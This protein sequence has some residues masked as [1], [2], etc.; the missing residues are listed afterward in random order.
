MSMPVNVKVR[1]SSF[2]KSIIN[3]YCEPAVQLNIVSL[4]EC[5]FGCSIN[6]ECHR[7]NNFR[8]CATHSP[9]HLHRIRLIIAANLQVDRTFFCICR[10]VCFGLF[11]TAR[12]IETHLKHEFVMHDKLTTS[13][14]IYVPH[15]TSR[16]KLCPFQIVF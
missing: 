9:C 2:W 5:L 16:S 3:Y 10:C 1:Q 4:I 12:I 7:A 8:L 6:F 11:I 14:N 13:K 15:K